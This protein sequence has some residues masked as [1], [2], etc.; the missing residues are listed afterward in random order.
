M[1]DEKTTEEP[2]KKVKQQ[3]SGINEAM[4]TVMRE[5]GAIGKNQK[6]EQ[7]KFKYRGISD[8]YD[9]AHKAMAAAGVYMLPEVLS[10]AR[11]ERAAKSGGNLI[12]TFLTVRYKFVATDGSFQECVVCGE[13]MDSGD[14]SSNK[15][16]AAA[17]KYAITQTFI[18]PY[19]EMADGDADTPEA[20]TKQAGAMHTGN[21]PPAAKKPSPADWTAAYIAGLAPVDSM[22]ALR[23]Y[24]AERSAALVRL[25]KVAP[26]LRDRIEM[27]IAE[28]RHSLELAENNPFK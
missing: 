22:E 23:E 3:P 17:H 1:T 21:P 14:K 4:L 5:M 26:D 25:D 10:H 28:K 24:T 15:A 6:N 27:A 19:S 16:L 18:T 9:A 13:G 12:Y 20:S 7:Q 11:E 2:G 8:I